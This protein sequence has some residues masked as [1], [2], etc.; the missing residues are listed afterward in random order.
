[1]A[2]LL[3][4][5]NLAVSIMFKY[6][7]DQEDRK[8]LE[9]MRL[10]DELKY[11]KAQ[12]N[13]HFFMN[14]L[15]N[16]HALVE[17]DP[18]KAQEMLLELSKLM[19]YVL[20]EGDNDVAT[21]Q[22]EVRFLTTYIELMRQRYPESKVCVVTDLRSEPQEDVPIPPLLFIAFVENAFKHGVSYRK[23]TEI[24]V[25]LRLI[26]GKIHFYCR[27][28][29]P[30]NEGAV[31]VPGGVGLEN[32]RRRLDLLYGSDYSLRIDDLDEEFIVVLIIPSL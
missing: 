28:T 4:G 23:R 9:N 30:E 27:N 19:R 16:I 11:L 7:R 5:L 20:Y 15:N 31:S 21:L 10:K 1:M 6:Y 12:I 29:K 2:L 18:V 22:S 17:T 13:P 8:L 32:A 3:L 26:S 24:E 25:S 14:M